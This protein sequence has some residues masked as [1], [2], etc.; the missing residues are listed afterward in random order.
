MTISDNPMPRVLLCLLWLIGA[1]AVYAQLAPP[2]FPVTFQQAIQYAV[3][4]YPAI[5]AS[6]ARISAQQAGVDLA[7][8]AYLPRLDSGFQINRATRN[9]VA[10]TL[11]LPGPPIPSITGPVSDSIS[12]SSVWGSASGLL[13]SWEAYDF[14]LRGATVGLAEAQVTRARAGADLTQLDVGVRTAGAFL[15]LATAQETVRAARA[16]V[17]RQDVFANSVA[18]LVRN[19]LRP[20]ADDSRAQAELALARIQLIQAEQ[21]EQIARANLAQWLGVT[22]AALQIAAGSLLD[23]P[24]PPPVTPPATSAHPLAATQMANVL[25]SRAFQNVLGRSYFPHIS[26]QTALAA[27]GSGALGDG[28]SLGGPRGLFDVDASN[29]AAGVTATFPLFDWFSVRERRRIEAQNERAELATYDRIVRELSSQSEQAQAEMDGARRVADNTPI[30]LAS[31]R[32]LEQQSRARY[33]AGL[34]TIIEVADAQRLLLQSEV[35]DAVARLGVW[36]AL[37][38]D[39]AA[40]GDIAELLR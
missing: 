10:G 8:T 17:E 12:A 38:A 27:R 11:L 13:L 24:P 23:M 40:K 25:S 9:N 35:G 21:A 1:E 34:A 5:Q 7:R 4:N 39:A 3:A 20:G 16:N 36:R 15:Q 32:V 37:V 29:W 14:G 30:Q 33:D 19:Q 26:F 2:A 22:S 28:T 18:V 31:A 6:M